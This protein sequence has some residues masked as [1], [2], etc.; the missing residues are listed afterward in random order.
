MRLKLA[1]FINLFVL[2][3]KEFFLRTLLERLSKILHLRFTKIYMHLLFAMYM[4]K[5]MCVFVFV[6]V[7]VGVFMFFWD[8]DNFYG[9]QHV[10]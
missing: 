1:L 8:P 6:Y 5:C 9:D 10:P 7:F 4:H 2:F 3:D